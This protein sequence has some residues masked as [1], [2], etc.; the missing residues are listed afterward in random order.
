[1]K[2]RLFRWIMTGFCAALLTGCS[3]GAAGA[4]SSETAQ[5]GQGATAGAQDTQQDTQADP[6]AEL[7]ASWGAPFLDDAAYFEGIDPENYVTI[8]E[9][10]G[11]QITLSA[12]EVDEASIDQMIAYYEQQLPG[13]PVTDRDISQNGDRLLV[14]FSGRYK[15]DGTVFEGGTAQDQTVTIGGAGYIPGF[16]EGMEGHRVGE[17]FDMEV[18]FPEDYHAED[19]RGRDVIFTVTIKSISAQPSF[20][21]ENVGDLMNN[22]FGVPDIHSMADQREH[23]RGM[24]LEEA[25]ASNT[26]MTYNQLMEKCLS[27]ATFTEEMPERIVARYMSLIYSSA[28]QQA[29]MYQLY[30][31]PDL[32]AYSLIEQQ[33]AMEGYEGTVATYLEE[34]AEEQVKSMLVFCAIA[35]REEGLVPTEA[36]VEENVASVL[37]QSGIADEA[38][39][40][41]S[42][43][44]RLT[45]M[46]RENLLS[47][48]V[49]S[50]LE[51][52]AEITYE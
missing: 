32:T 26:E 8:G 25:Q 24:Y 52:H 40:E 35:Q 42:Y 5:S 4:S 50:F 46:M 31:N 3:S 2:K 17:T 37:S 47:D 10:K 30:G 29:Y 51:E 18:T 20:T 43:G 28:E 36:E 39:Y 15:D 22:S 14:D 48:N 11:L 1:M 12:P 6:A 45:S 34:L 23:I 19:L 16:A 21:D 49:L 27:E 9:Y 41:Q 13:V 44:Y 33:M 7:I 38:A